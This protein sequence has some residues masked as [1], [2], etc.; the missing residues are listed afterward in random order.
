MAENL[1]FLDMLARLRRFGVRPGLDGITELCRRLGDPQKRARSVHI[2]GTN[3]KGAVAAMVDAALSRAGAA[4]LRY[5]SPH[6]VSVNERFSICGKTVQDDLLAEC[7]AET[8]S[9]AAGLEITFFEA[10]TAMAFLMAVKAGVDWMVLETGL[11]GRLDATNI[12]E[13]DISVITKIGLDHCGVLGNTVA[14]IAAEKAGIVKAGRPVVL[15]RN[16]DEARRVVESAAA[17][18][19]SRF[20]Y[21]PDIASESEIPPAFPLAGAFNRENA[22]TALAA[23]KT[24]AAGGVAWSIDGFADVVWPGRFQT[25]GDVIVD[26]AHNPPAMEAL[27]ASLDGDVVLVAGFCAD[28]AVDEA[29]SAIAPRTVEA[30]AV[31]TNSPRSLEAGE[32]AAR[33]RACGMVASPSPCLASAI[34]EA[35]RRAVAHGG[36]KVLVCGSLFLAG[37]ALVLLGAAPGAGRF[38][39]EEPPPETLTG[40]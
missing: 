27:A 37:E 6:L 35:R 34:E 30:F 39:P 28:K 26:G 2:A 17:A 14:K 23:L 11:G 13:S 40:G 8:E 22:V 25:I 19:S 7:A 16:T 10:F 3:G 1:S 9:A 36:A 29:L 31:K 4:T 12:V 5:T 38:D 20:I 21:A 32:L 33:M 18:R 15:G 24:L